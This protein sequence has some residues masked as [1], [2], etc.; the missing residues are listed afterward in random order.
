MNQKLVICDVCDTLYRSNTTFDFIRYFVGKKKNSLFII[1]FYLLTSKKS[2]LFFFLLFISKASRRDWIR[3][4]ALKLLKGASI[5]DLDSLATSF[6]IDFLIDRSNVEVFKLLSHDTILVSSSI[7]PV[8]ATIAKANGLK[9]ESSRLEWHQGKATGNL[10]T[11][12]TGRKHEIAR[13]LF[14]LGSFNRLQVIT[15]NR[16]DWGL[17]KLAN[18]RFVIIGKESEKKFWR[19]LNPTFIKI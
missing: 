2:P 16:S 7:D 5:Q 9:F 12:I 19:D 18:E 14:S 17:V 10:A 4:L 13:K 15:D 8:V 1:W 11:D 3:T 6:Y